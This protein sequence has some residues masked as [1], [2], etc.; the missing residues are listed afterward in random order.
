MTI[1]EKPAYWLTGCLLVIV[2]GFGAWVV[3]SA[4]ETPETTAPKEMPKEA[5]A[6]TPKET[7]AETP[8]ETPKETPAQ[9]PQETPAETPKEP[10]K[11]KPKETLG[12]ARRSPGGTIPLPRA[13]LLKENTRLIDVEGVILDLKDDLKKSPVS[14]PVFQ[15]R[16]GL[17]YFILL[18][19]LLL[20][21]VIGETAHGE[22]PVRVRG[23]VTIYGG[24]NY[25]LLDW[26]AV[27]QE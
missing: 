27:K 25:L 16:E 4:Q 26:A 1:L 17:N 7:P 20:Q 13:P 23:T 10:P 12:E 11:E 3:C 6:E 22:R 2:L 5:P 18:E 21:K 9:T 19:N 24:R 15:P 8:K 14:R